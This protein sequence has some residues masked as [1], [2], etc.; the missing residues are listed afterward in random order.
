MIRGKTAATFLTTVFVY[1]LLQ[2]AEPV[3]NLPMRQ[4][5]AI[6]AKTILVCAGIP[7]SRIGTMLL[8]EGIQFE[9]EP[10]CSGSILLRILLTGGLL[11]CLLYA[12][13][14]IYARAVALVLVF[15]LAMVANGLRIAVLAGSGFFGKVLHPGSITHELI[16]IMVFLA[17]MVA[18]VHVL[19]SFSSRLESSESVD[20]KSDGFLQAGVCAFLF[21]HMPFLLRCLSAWTGNGYDPQDHIGF[22]FVLLAAIGVG[23]LGWKMTASSDPRCAALL[24]V[25]SLLIVIGS[26]VIAISFLLALSFLF[27]IAAL[28]CALRGRRCL[29]SFF[30][31]AVVAYVGFPTVSLQL[32]AFTGG[33]AWLVGHDGIWLRI[34]VAVGGL[35]CAYSLAPRSGQHSDT[36]CMLT[37]G[38]RFGL[39]L[40]TLIALTIQQWHLIFQRSRQSSDSASLTISYLQGDW[41]GTDAQ[42][43]QENYYRPEEVWSRVYS[44]DRLSVS[45]LISSSGGDPRRNHPPEFC[46]TSE[47]W[48]IESQHIESLM[49]NGEGRKGISR[50]KMKRGSMTCRLAYW[51]T[52]GESV[53][54]SYPLMVLSDLMN[55][56]KRI[57]RQWYLFR[58]VA[59][60]DSD[61]TV[62]LEDFRYHIAQKRQQE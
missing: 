2:I 15:L 45:V 22:V 44:H 48:A 43:L 55:R 59:A 1:L 6:V 30:C 17:A 40:L 4:V 7:A 38:W 62:F 12:S 61:L 11:L 51:F 21:L 9:V 49:L 54:S 35:T 20:R 50:I 27:G 25:I 18:I 46:L 34:V 47:G 58:I 41:V 32:R 24:F 56:L 5:S 16:G 19:S 8:C 28:L 26:A 29:P 52:D 37:R 3:I 39:V 13:I 14:P 23:V 60:D 42:I 33:V 36:H 31:L 10:A 53:C 57:D